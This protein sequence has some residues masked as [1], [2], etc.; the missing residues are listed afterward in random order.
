VNL[1]LNIFENM[2]CRENLFS[3]FTY[4]LVKVNILLIFG[5]FRNLIFCLEINVRMIVPY[6]FH[7]SSNTKYPMFVKVYL[8]QAK[9]ISISR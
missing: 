9:L 1:L 5:N 8:Y 4:L 3:K 2:Q 7:S 6:D